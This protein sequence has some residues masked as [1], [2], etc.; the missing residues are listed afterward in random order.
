[1]LTQAVIIN[2]T[3]FAT[4]KLDTTAAELEGQQEGVANRYVKTL[5]TDTDA[6]SAPSPHGKAS[7]RV[8]PAASVFVSVD[9]PSQ[10]GPQALPSEAVLLRFE[11][12]FHSIA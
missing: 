3:T 9:K 6:A 12:V 2:S 8:A 4:A 5:D 11:R 10:A 1:M 7:A